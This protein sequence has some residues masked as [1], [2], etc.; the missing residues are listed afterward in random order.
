MDCFAQ[1]AEKKRRSTHEGKP[2]YSCRFRDPRRT[3]SVMV[4]AD[5]IF[6]EECQSTWQVG[7]FFK[8]RGIFSEH[9]KYGPQIEAEM[10]RPIQ[11]RD[12]EDGFTELDFMERSRFDP[13]E[14]LKELEA[15]VSAEIADL[16]LRNLVLALLQ[17]L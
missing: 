14:M 11:E 4:W 9:E 16:P 1:L 12:R 17:V 5:S 6:F 10:V 15:L 2:F 13:A 8:I 7:G 3:A